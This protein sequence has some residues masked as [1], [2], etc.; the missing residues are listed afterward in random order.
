MGH[1]TKPQISVTQPATCTACAH[2]CPRFLAME[3]GSEPAMKKIATALAARIIRTIQAKMSSVDIYAI[4]THS[5]RTAAGGVQEPPFQTDAKRIAIHFLPNAAA[6]FK[7][8]GP[9]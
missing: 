9:Y 5:A 1:S 2:G 7:I 6:L 8:S 3:P 4:L